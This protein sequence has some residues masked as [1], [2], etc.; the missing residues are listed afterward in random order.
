VNREMASWGVV[1]T[2]V[3]VLVTILSVVLPPVRPDQLSALPTLPIVVVVL[4]VI[5]AALFLVVV[6]RAARSNCPAVVG[7]VCGIIGLLLAGTLF[8]S[9][10]AIVF[11]AAAV[12]LGRMTQER[13]RGLALAAVVIGAVAV[14]ADLVTFF[15]DRLPF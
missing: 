8:W 5:A 3:A 12:L 13:G 15:V 14:V 1:S 2:I 7:L 9:G 10:L 4:L 11:G 6:P